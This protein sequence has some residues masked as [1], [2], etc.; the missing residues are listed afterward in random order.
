VP[1][2]SVRPPLEACRNTGRVGCRDRGGTGASAPRSL[3]HHPASSQSAL[4]DGPR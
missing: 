1:T 3:P 2:A 4:R